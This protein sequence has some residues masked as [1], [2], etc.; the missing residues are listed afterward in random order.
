MHTMM[1][2]SVQ[3]IIKEIRIGSIVS[4]L[5]GSVGVELVDMSVTVVEGC[6]VEFDSTVAETQNDVFFLMPQHGVLYFLK[7]IH[8]LCSC[9]SLRLTTIHSLKH[10]HS[11]SLN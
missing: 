5:R 10:S 9:Q 2:N 1:S 7:K 3:R 8:S 4:A 11:N 6:S